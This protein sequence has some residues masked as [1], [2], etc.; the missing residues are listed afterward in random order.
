MS[1]D[2]H[3]GWTHTT[4]ADLD[5]TEGSQA[6]LAMDAAGSLYGTTFGNGAQQKGNVFKLTKNGGTWTYTSLHDFTG[7]SDGAYPFSSVV[8][9]AQ[10]NLYGT[11]SSG[12]AHGL[13]VVWKIAQ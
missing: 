6:S 7:G 8:I 10:G 3:G 4:L 12:G 9:D 2:G 13:G 5:G 1:P 11:A